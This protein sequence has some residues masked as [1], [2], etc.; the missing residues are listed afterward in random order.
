[1]RLPSAAEKE[2][3]EQSGS[4][5]QA[6][7]VRLLD[8]FKLNPQDVRR[9]TWAATDLKAWQDQAVVLVE[10]A[11]GQDATLLEG[12]GEPVRLEIAGASARRLPQAS[13][14]HPF[15]A[16][17][18]HLVLTGPEPLLRALASRSEPRWES[19]AMSQLLALKA[20]ENTGDFLL[21]VDLGAAREAG[22][23]LPDRLL[24]VW[25]AGRDVW[26]RLWR[27]PQGMGLSLKTS[28]VLQGELLLACD[29]ET[30]AKELQ[31]SLAKQL[32]P[33]AVKAIQ[34][35]S[36]S[37][38]AKEAKPYQELL[39]L[40][41]TALTGAE[42][43]VEGQTAWV[44]INWGQDLPAAARATLGSL[45]PAQAD[46]LAAALE[47]DKGN[48]GRL[49]QALEAFRKA[50]GH[51]P[52]GIHGT[53]VLP[54][55]T[56]LSWLA[57]MLA[58]LG[59]P[60][61]QKELQSGYAWDSP[62]NKRVTQQRLEEVVNPALGPSANEAGFPATHYVGVAG[63]QGKDGTLKPGLFSNDHPPRPE[64]IKAGASNTLATLGV[65]R[66]PG[67]WA[68]G[69]RS[70]VRALTQ[71]PY[72]NGPDGFGSGQPHGMLAGMADG[73]VRFFAKNVDPE[74]F[75]QLA[76]INGAEK[77][78]EKPA[79]EQTAGADPPNQDSA[80]A[81]EEME[82]DAAEAGGAAPAQVDVQSRLADRVPKV[83]FPGTPLIEAIRLVDRMS[84]VRTTLDVDAL[85][86]S[87]VAIFDP[88][89]LEL[90]DPSIQEILEAI[91]ANRRLACV[92]EGDQIVLTSPQKKQGALRQ[93]K[94]DIS[95]LVRPGETTGPELAQ[96]IQ[97]LVAPTS[98]RSAGGQG[99]MEF[100][101][102]SLVVSQTGSVHF[103]VQLF[104]DKLRVARGLAPQG[105][106]ILDKS[107]LA[108]RFDRARAKLRQPV[109]AV[110]VA[111]TPL[112]SILAYLEQAT[113][114]TILVNWEVL[115]SEEIAPNIK[116]ALRVHKQPLSECL[117]QLLHPLGLGYR[118][119]GP[120]VYEVIT[121]K[122]FAS[123]L[124]VEFYPVGELLKRGMNAD[125]LVD[126]VKG[127][128]GGA[129]WSDAGGSGVL[130]FDKPS[131]TLVALQSQGV[132]VKLQ[133][134][135][136][137]ILTDLGGKPPDA[138]LPPKPPPRR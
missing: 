57:A 55:E 58:S 121:R 66:D 136:S 26:H 43:G 71:R 129:V 106:Q 114:S 49:G 56:Q 68:Q 15:V 76:T 131:Q 4:L 38:A 73:S 7:A 111:K 14:S 96:T 89:T 98:W 23:R 30:P 94:Y 25:P 95:D 75:E 9:I 135:L 21:Y 82:A 29:G 78:S 45:S 138:L 125:G 27:I 18:K 36:G 134:L 97:K 64:D 51:F 130:Y 137:K 52:P 41:Q 39:K 99:T 113:Q 13:W 54:P 69:G 128:L 107:G 46:W 105:Q 60:D 118:I 85:A 53:T 31:A 16:V 100:S 61:W 83:K 19:R 42:C 40:G 101:G 70:T 72:I 22:W 88:I 17:D 124:E 116:G 104:C 127:D 32:I 20:R 115:A 86:E 79:P 48:H 63:V 8:T 10:L 2:V 132:Q 11:P 112:E 91:A 81:D 133:L 122:S 80:E 24:D 62:Q 33:M 108:T 5:W 120:D 77:P 92:G 50:K 35:L 1:M 6:T 87:G 119:V 123:R 12:R 84:T 37:P 3:L 44:R 47:I 90:S 34:T 65:A 59:H 102:G 67:P 110:F 126:R 93:A 74:V 103:Q 117:M 109:T 28:G